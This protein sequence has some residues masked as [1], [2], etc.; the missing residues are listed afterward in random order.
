MPF[1]DPAALWEWKEGKDRKE[2]ANERVQKQKKGSSMTALK[3]GRGRRQRWEAKEVKEEERQERDAG[4]LQ[5]ASGVMEILQ[6]CT[7]SLLSNVHLILQI[8]ESKQQN[9]SYSG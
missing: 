6:Q 7:S 9:I 1:C 8:L 5:V 4:A 3:D 2:E